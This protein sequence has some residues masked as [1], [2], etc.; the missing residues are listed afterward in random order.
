LLAKR[1]GIGGIIPHQDDGWVLSGRDLVHLSPDAS[2]RVLFA[3]D[4]AYGFNDLGTTTSGDLLAGVLRFRPL[5]GDP[6]RNGQLLQIKADGTVE[7][8]T[9]EIVWPNGIGAT[10]DGGTVY[11]SDYA[12]K[13]V[14][15]VSLNDCSVHEFCRSP[16][17]SAN[18]LAL[19]CEGG[20]WVALGE[21]GGVARFHPD[22]QLTR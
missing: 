12:Q 2:Q 13:V 20:V 22:G 7:V 11:I 9:E 3:D 15:A 8:L 1:R 21:G 19:D 17:G 6:P 18:G 10:P 5:V 14:L 16:D 4:D